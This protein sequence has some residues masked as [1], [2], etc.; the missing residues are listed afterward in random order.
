MHRHL[1]DLLTSAGQVSGW[2]IDPPQTE[3]PRLIFQ[4]TGPEGTFT[5]WLV[6]SNNDEASFAQGKSF[7][8]G[9]RGTVGPGGFA[10]LSTLAA[11]LKAF[12]R[13]NGPLEL[14]TNFPPPDKEVSLIYSGQQMEIRLTLDCNEQCI[15]CNSHGLAENLATDLEHATTMLEQARDSGARKLVI[16]GGEPLLIAWLPELISLARKLEFFPITVQTNGLLLSK[17]QNLQRLDASPPDDVLISIHGPTD[18]ILQSITGVPRSLSRKLEAL[19]KCRER[20]FRTLVSIVICRQNM[21]AAEETV[22]LL[23][24]QS[25]RPDLV[26]FSFVAPS[27]RARDYGKDVVPSMSKTAP[28]LL[29]ALR[30]G[31]E[32]GLD[33]VLVEYCGLPLCVE[34]GLEPFAEAFNP[35]APLGIPFDKKKIAACETCRFSLRCSGIFKNY[36]SLYGEDEFGL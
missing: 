21:A 12:E 32:L 16:S 33:V 14:E 7:K 10:L 27:G 15:F 24:A 26:A 13:I 8:L 17:E 29:A 4:T 30:T 31:R 25:L 23:A 35:E 6:P 5:F 11:R 19:R 2:D 1:T 36:L 18:E 22:R 34:P 3:G 28:L 9:Y 20:G